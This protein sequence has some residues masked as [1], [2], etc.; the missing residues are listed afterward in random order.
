[1]STWILLRGLTREARHWGSFGAHL[2]AAAGLGA[3]SFTLLDLPGNGREN[4]ETA[5]LDVANMTAFIR[6]R[7][8]ALGLKPPYSLFAMSLGGMVATDWAQRHAQEI[9]RLVLVNTS[10]RPFCAIRERLQVAAWPQLLRAGAGW[11]DPMRCESII[12]GVTCNRVDS[13]DDDVTAWMT[14]R[15]VAR[16]SAANAL[17]QLWAAA[18]FRAHRQPPRCPVLLLSSK[19][20][21]LVDPACS[22]H[23][24]AQ[25]KTVH[26]QHPWAGHDLPHDDPAWTATAISDWLRTLP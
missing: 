25:W 10:M 21:K 19:A 15:R 13:F 24:A 9:D 12:H 8:A 16:V 26:M 7:A 17:R 20:D 22:T 6:S 18:R 3:D 23:I 14:I 4:A 1:M 11:N 2:S 5:P